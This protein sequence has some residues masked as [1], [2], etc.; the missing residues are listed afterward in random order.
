VFCFLVFSCHTQN[1]DKPKKDLA[2]CGD[3]TNRKL[4]KIKNHT[5]CWQPIRIYYLNVAIFKEDN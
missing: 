2:K 3:K 4:E 5:I 1:G